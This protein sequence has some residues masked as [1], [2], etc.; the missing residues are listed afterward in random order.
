M[1][2]APAPPSRD[3]HLGCKDG[4]NPKMPFSVKHAMHRAKIETYAPQCTSSSHTSTSYLA[5]Q[6]S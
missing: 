5:D 3:S 1:P 4:F 2:L 6:V